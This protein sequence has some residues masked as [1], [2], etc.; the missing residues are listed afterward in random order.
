MKRAWALAFAIS[1]CGGQAAPALPGAATCPGVTLHDEP[2]PAAGTD[3]IRGCLTYGWTRVLVGSGTFASVG[4]D[5]TIAALSNVSGSNWVTVLSPAGDTLG[6]FPVDPTGDLVR[7]APDG[8][9]VTA[10][11]TGSI[12]RFRRDGTVVWTIDAGK[13]ISDLAVA[14]DG[15]IL[16]S[17]YVDDST[18]GPAHAMLATYDRDGVG[19]W[20]KT[21]QHA[22]TPTLAAR[23]DGSVAMTTRDNCAPPTPCSTNFD[24]NRLDAVTA[25]HVEATSAVVVLDSEG[26]TIGVSH[27]DQ[28]LRHPRGPLFVRSAFLGA[29]GMVAQVRAWGDETSP[30]S[31]QV[32]VDPNGMGHPVSLDVPASPDALISLDAQGAFCWARHFAPMDATAHAQII[33]LYASRAGMALDVNGDIY[34]V[35]HVFYV[36]PAGQ[37]VWR[38]D[39][40]NDGS[41]NDV[42]LAGI[43][44]VGDVVLSGRFDAA[45]DFDPGPEDD[46]KSADEG[47]RRYV[48]VLRPCSPR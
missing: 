35:H 27:L 19:T 24:P 47:H 15:G 33:G 6:S 25:P 2:V 37:I 38:L 18:A 5:G 26:Q 31:L 21:I 7:I 28:D 36:S 14:P 8:S 45:V 20:S 4:A 23:S 13:A 10:S 43:D 11:L 17:A 30:Q 16:V 41:M 32:D 44:D 22:A 42:S 1:G 12:R 34:K 46:T 29:A 9:V 40:A 3:S 39:R 48:S